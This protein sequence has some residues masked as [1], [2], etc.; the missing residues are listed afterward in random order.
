LPISLSYDSIV[1]EI[2]KLINLLIST[3]YTLSISIIG[4]STNL[5]KN[6]TL[7]QIIYEINNSVS[8]SLKKFS[9]HFSQKE[10]P[11]SQSN[12]LILIF[13]SLLEDSDKSFPT[14]FKLLGSFVPTIQTNDFNSLKEIVSSFS[15][16]FN[17]FIKTFKQI[18][19]NISGQ[20][21]KLS[22]KNSL[23]QSSSELFKLIKNQL[24]Y[25]KQITLKSEVNKSYDFR[26]ITEYINF[27]LSIVNVYNTLYEEH[28]EAKQLLIQTLTN[29]FSFNDSKIIQLHSLINKVSELISNESQTLFK[30]DNL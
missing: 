23:L 3:I 7:K 19:L 18:F 20:E 6:P 14:V 10:Y 8:Y 11:K 25:S 13:N 15:E 16:Q 21:I 24:S 26:S 17:N 27:F 4:Q 28:S 12:S 9:A 2:E 1:S 5:Y 30:T 29:H 22:P